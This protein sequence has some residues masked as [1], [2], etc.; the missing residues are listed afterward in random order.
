VLLS[1]ACAAGADRPDRGRIPVAVLGDSDSHSYHDELHFRDTTLRGG[2]YRATTFQWTEVWARLRPTEVDLGAWGRWGNRG[3]VAALRRA[4]GLEGRAPPKQDFQYDFAFSGARCNHLVETM[5]AQTV[6]LV[7]L[8]D[9]DAERWSRG[10]VVIRIGINSVGGLADLDEYATTGPSPAVRAR[11]RDCTRHIE[12]AVAR[13][14]AGHPTTRVVLV[15]IFDDSNWAKLL[16]RWHDPAA[17]ANI[18]TVLDVFDD[19]LRELAAGD[20]WCAFLDERAWFRRH[21]GGRAG[22]GRP[23]YRSVNVGGAVPVSNTAGDHPRNLAV[24]D[25]HA[26]TVANG[27]WL[28]ELISLIETRWRLGFTPIRLDEIA[29]L[30]DPTGD[31]GISDAASRREPPV[32]SSSPRP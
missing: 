26:G 29:R 5:A 20:P 21:W 23:A 7:R 30:A 15:G 11:L 32:P 9:R 13:I 27:L 28:Q 4:V 3:T 25:G 12:R 1:V 17:L 14:R 2:A 8:M 18:A 31:L 24:A 16:D 22:D 10:V 19:H 6:P